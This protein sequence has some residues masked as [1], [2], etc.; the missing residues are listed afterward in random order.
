VNVDAT[1]NLS[2]EEAAVGIIARDHEGQPH[3][4]EWKLVGCC[5][6]A[7]EA[8]ALALLEGVRLAEYWPRETP[9]VFESD[10]AELVRKVVSAD[11]DNS[12]LSAIIFDI[13]EFVAA[14]QLC[15]VQKT[16]REQNG[17]T[18]NLACFAL[19]SRSSQISFSFLPLCIQD[20]VLSDRYCCMNQTGVS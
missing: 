11:R 4:M 10:C 2:I 14:R 8:E 6:D 7:E 12:M 5:R 16:W 20:L 13:K 18:H 9:V 19:K 15:K 1:F 3:F 17:I